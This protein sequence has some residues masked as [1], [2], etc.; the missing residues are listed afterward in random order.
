MDQEENTMMYPEE[1]RALERAMIREEFLK[2]RNKAYWDP[3]M[4]AEFAG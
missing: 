3:D 2:E 1:E 4:E